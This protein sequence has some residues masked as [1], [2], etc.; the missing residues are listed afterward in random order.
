LPNIRSFLPYHGFDSIFSKIT[1][2]SS[3]Q[4]FSLGHP[5]KPII[6]K[7]KLSLKIKN[8]L[9]SPDFV[10]WT[11]NPS[12]LIKVVTGKKL[13]S[14]KFKAEIVVGMLDK[15]VSAPFYIQVFS[16]Q[17]RVLRIFIYNINGKG[18][19]TIE[20]AR[21]EQTCEEVIH[22]SQG[23]M[24]RFISNQIVSVVGRKREVRYFAYT[25]RDH[26]ILDRFQ[27]QREIEN[28]IIPDYL[29]YGRD[30]KIEFIIHQICT[31]NL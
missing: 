13:D 28:L 17:S 31:R 16:I 23:I 20:K 3:S 5:V 15:V 4:Y 12:P 14:Q 6:S 21:D 27:N 7:G 26:E 30:Q 11:S 24:S 9:T 1:E 22:F 18:C 10:I 25:V 2:K 19:F 29:S 8:E